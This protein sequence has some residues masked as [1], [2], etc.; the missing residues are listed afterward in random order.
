MVQRGSAV[1]P[2]HESGSFETKLQNTSIEQ[3]LRG[4]KRQIWP[5][6]ASFYIEVFGLMQHAKAEMCRELFI[7]GGRIGKT[8]HSGARIDYLTNYC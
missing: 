8:F 2:V 4:E 1:P 3:H 6:F 7:R 5:I